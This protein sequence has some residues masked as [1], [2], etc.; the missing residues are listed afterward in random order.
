MTKVE[1]LFCIQQCYEFFIVC[2]LRLFL[3][4]FLVMIS[5]TVIVNFSLFALYR[6][7]RKTLSDLTGKYKVT[8]YLTLPAF[9]FFLSFFVIFYNV[10]YKI[11]VLS[12]VIYGKE[13]L[14]LFFK[15]ML[16]K[17]IDSSVVKR[18]S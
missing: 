9:F 11:T 18:S 3:E 5:E 7:E 12:I 1:Q 2:V 6:K 16:T 13:K 4:F 10:V 17:Y 8:L 14:F 15:Y